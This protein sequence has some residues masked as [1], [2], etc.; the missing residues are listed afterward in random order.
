MVVAAL[1]D[2]ILSARADDLRDVG[3]RVLKLM[4]GAEDKNESLPDKTVFIVCYELFPSVTVFF[5]FNFLLGFFIVNSRP[6]L[7]CEILSQIFVLF[8]RRND[9]QTSR[10]CPYAGC[11]W[12]Q[13]IAL[14]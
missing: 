14:Y 12:R 3:R 9:G 5:I 4:V 13:A 2:P 8:H 7:H 1:N 6:T 11:R 10:D